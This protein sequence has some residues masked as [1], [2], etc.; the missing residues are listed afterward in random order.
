M[1][2]RNADFEI[3]RRTGT[4]ATLATLTT[5]GL[6]SLVANLMSAAIDQPRQTGDQA[7]RVMEVTVVTGRRESAAVV[8]TD[9]SKDPRPQLI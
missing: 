8:R 9:T 1:H 5:I 2:H 3:V 6:F 4:C 7:V